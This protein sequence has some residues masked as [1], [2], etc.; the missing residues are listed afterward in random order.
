MRFALSFVLKIGRS[1]KMIRALTLVSLFWILYL[2]A[3][4]LPSEHVV[5]RILCG[6]GFMV[7]ILYILSDALDKVE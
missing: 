4:G 2:L 7:V 1:G 6:I 3:V 5:L